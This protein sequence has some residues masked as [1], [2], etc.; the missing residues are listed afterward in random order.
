VTKS[1]NTDLKEEIAIRPTSETG[2]VMWASNK[3][4]S[5]FL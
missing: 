3:V 1:G 5:F 4:L 2:D